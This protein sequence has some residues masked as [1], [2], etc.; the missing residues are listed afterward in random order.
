M[1][2]LELVAF[3]LISVGTLLKGV[4]M[5]SKLSGKTQKYKEDKKRLEEKKQKRIEAKK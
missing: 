2:L 5:V 3:G 1:L 4:T